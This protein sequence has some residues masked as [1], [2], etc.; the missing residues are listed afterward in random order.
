MNVFHSEQDAIA[1]QNGQPMRPE[2]MLIFY[3][4]DLSGAGGKILPS[5]DVLNSFRGTQDEL[6]EWLGNKQPALTFAVFNPNTT[7]PTLK[8]RAR[9]VDFSFHDARRTHQLFPAFYI[10]EHGDIWE[11]D[12]YSKT[13]MMPGPSATLREVKPC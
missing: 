11:T 8:Y 6:R 13:P 2:A 9:G 5:F 7:P 10:G 3:F 4:R 12:S 1:V